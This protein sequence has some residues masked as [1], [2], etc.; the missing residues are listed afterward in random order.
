MADSAPP[1]SASLPRA[2]AGLDAELRAQFDLARDGDARALEALCAAMRPRL[3]RAAFAILRDAD[4][5]DDVAQEAL[6]RAVTRRFLFLGRGSVSGWMT[7]IAMNLAKNRLRDGKRRREI[8]EAA[9]PEEKSARGAEASGPRAP[10]DVADERQTRA[11][12]VAAVEQLPERQRDVVRLHAVAQLD[13]KE[14]AE[15]LGMSEANVRVT[16]SNA[17]KKLVAVLGDARGDP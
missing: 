5:A 15:V 10:D 2:N 16:F 9:S 17:K 8:L 12:L 4:E 11:R 7:R 1:A 3:Y 14:V 6:I 13:F